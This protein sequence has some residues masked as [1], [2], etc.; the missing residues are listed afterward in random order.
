MAQVGVH[1]IEFNIIILCLFIYK[2]G[3]QCITN[4][5]SLSII[6]IALI[7][8]IHRPFKDIIIRE[9]LESRMLVL[10]NVE[11]SD[12]A[13]GASIWTGRFFSFNQVWG[14]DWGLTFVVGK[15]QVDLLIEWLGA[16]FVELILLRCFD[17]V[18]KWNSWYIY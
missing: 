16:L 18:Y 13:K 9:I 6:I 11:F 12:L 3:R 14:S 15:F 17:C 5:I 7:Q 1:I 8:Q 4:A 10:Q 2:C